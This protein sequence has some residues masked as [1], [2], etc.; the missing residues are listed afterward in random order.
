MPFTKVIMMDWTGLSLAITALFTGLGLLATNLVSAYL[1]IKKLTEGQA[2]SAASA[3]AVAQEKKRVDVEASIQRAEVVVKTDAVRDKL[4]ETVRGLDLAAKD[5][6]L[7]LK[8]TTESQAAKLDGAVSAMSDLMVVLKLR[9]E[10]SAKR[11]GL[12]M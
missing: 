8:Q 4:T 6:K 12:V 7:T 1:Q 10:A 3:E 5:V 9:A 11:K 2:A